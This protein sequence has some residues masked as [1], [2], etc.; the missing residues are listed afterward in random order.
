MM[1]KFAQFCPKTFEC[2]L[3]ASISSNKRRST[4]NVQYGILNLF[5]CSSMIES[6]LADIN[7]P[8][9]EASCS[10]CSW[11]VGGIRMRFRSGIWFCYRAW[12]CVTNGRQVSIY[13]W[14]NL[15]GDLPVN[16][17]E[18]C[19]FADSF[20]FPITNRFQWIWAVR[21]RSV[22]KCI[23]SVALGLSVQCCWSPVPQRLSSMSLAFLWEMFWVT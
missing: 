18:C 22:S 4:P 2:W 3:T 14:F 11:M 1:L 16:H 8:I 19:W 13:K 7:V 9:T 12:C 17:C 23:V 21:F 10:F 5:T 6:I 20:R 15:V